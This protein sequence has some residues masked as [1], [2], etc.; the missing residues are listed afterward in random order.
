MLLILGLGLWLYYNYK[1]FLATD[2]EDAEKNRHRAN[3]RKIRIAWIE[4]RVFEQ[5]Y[6]DILGR[7]LDGFSARITKDEDS[8]EASRYREAW[9][10]RLFGA[11]PFTEGSYILCLR[12]ALVYPVV[13]FLITWFPGSTGEFSGLAFF[14]SFS[15]E[16]RRLTENGNFI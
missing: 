9:S 13:T 10:V 2:S 5:R 8:L 1:L 14:R 12:L 6:L 7:F 15:I 11:N 3:S 16:H 4:E